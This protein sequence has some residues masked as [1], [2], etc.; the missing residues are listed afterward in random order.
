MTAAFLPRLMDEATARAYLDGVDP[1][2]VAAPIY[3][4]RSVRWDRILIDQ[5]LNERSGV[6]SEPEAGDAYAK[7]QRRK[8][9]GKG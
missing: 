6:V 5:V 1:N 8:S 3:L 2:K 7:R 9:R 4:G